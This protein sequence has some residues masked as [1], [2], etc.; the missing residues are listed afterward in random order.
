MKER[1][2]ELKKM[3][4]YSCKRNNSSCRN[5]ICAGMLKAHKAALARVSLPLPRSNERRRSARECCPLKGFV[6]FPV[7]ETDLRHL[8]GQNM[9][10][11]MACRRTLRHN[12]IY[13][14]KHQGHQGKTREKNLKV[15]FNRPLKNMR[16]SANNP[17]QSLCRTVPPLSFGLPHT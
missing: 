7:G 14:H 11:H 12:K 2:S 13:I 15:S 4:I 3:K 5:R 17:S 6:S 1:K 16:N 10:S 8:L 9:A